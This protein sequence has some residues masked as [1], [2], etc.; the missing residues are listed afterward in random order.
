MA[1]NTLKRDVTRIG[2]AWAMLIGETDQL[3]SIVTQMIEKVAAQGRF[4]PTLD[5]AVA[6]Q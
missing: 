5:L 3:E 4:D 6:N 1:L 2:E